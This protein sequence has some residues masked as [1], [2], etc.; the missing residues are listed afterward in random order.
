MGRRARVPHRT[1]NQNQLVQ[2]LWEAGGHFRGQ[3]GS[4]R[5]AHVV[6]AMDIQDLTGV[7][8]CVGVIRYV[9]MARRLVG[10]PMSQHVER[11]AGVMLAE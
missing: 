8:Q 7:V 3:N 1:S 6:A 11:V 4:H 10:L 5:V 9:E 2:P